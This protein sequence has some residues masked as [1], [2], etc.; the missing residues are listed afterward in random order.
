M[1]PKNSIDE[2][3]KKYDPVSA[4][5]VFNADLFPAFPTKG[6]KK[7]KAVA[8]TTKKAAKAAPKKASKKAATSL[9]NINVP[10]E[11][12]AIP[13]Q[14]RPGVFLIKSAEGRYSEVTL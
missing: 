13:I 8:K 6:L 14:G 12:V 2:R 10:T 3:S 7:A 11:S 1:S 4:T 5:F 9:D